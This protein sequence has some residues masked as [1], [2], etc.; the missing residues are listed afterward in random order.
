MSPPSQTHISMRSFF[1]LK[2]RTHVNSSRFTTLTPRHRGTYN[3]LA[4]ARQ[5]SG[6]FVLSTTAWTRGCRPRHGGV[7]DRTLEELGIKSWANVPINQ[8]AFRANGS[9]AS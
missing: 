9:T 2:A 5:R 8:S 7:R 6:T 4:V 3:P 1:N